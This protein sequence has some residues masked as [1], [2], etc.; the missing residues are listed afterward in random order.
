MLELTNQDFQ[1][2]YDRLQSV[3]MRLGYILK[4]TGDEDFYLTLC[5]VLDD[6]RFYHG[7]EGRHS[8]MEVELWYPRTPTD[9]G[10]KVE[11]IEIA[12]M[13]V[14]ASDGIRVGYDFDRDGW[15]IKQPTEEGGD[16]EETAFVKSWQRHSPRQP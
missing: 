10:N 11:E 2:H 4:E 8:V 13:D 1:Q 14:R 7:P 12:L 9:K 3:K 5:G 15:V 6:I 16:H